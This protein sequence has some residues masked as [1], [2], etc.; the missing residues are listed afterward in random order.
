MFCVL[1]ARDV[2]SIS[3]I[4]LQTSVFRNA[5]MIVYVIAG[6]D[7]PTGVQLNVPIV[8]IF[9]A[10]APFSMLVQECTL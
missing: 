1:L 6:V 5:L 3:I 7:F 10:Y 8:Y 4:S 2:C 9:V